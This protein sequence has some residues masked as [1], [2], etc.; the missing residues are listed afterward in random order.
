MS[1]SS[2]LHLPSS[3]SDAAINRSKKAS[4]KKEVILTLERK[5]LGWSHSTV[6]SDGEGFVN[7]LTDCLWYLDGHHSALKDRCM[8][9]P[10]EIDQ[11]QGFNN[12]EASK[13]KRKEVGNLDAS[14][15]D[16][17]S[18]SLNKLLLQPFF[19]LKRWK[20]MRGAVTSF[21]E[22]MTKYAMYLRKKCDSVKT[23]HAAL[24]PVRSASDHESVCLISEAV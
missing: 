15:L 7:L 9:I 17:Y 19:D 5:N 18:N 23:H 6:S 24:Q 4:M 21:V 10:S 14:T 12:P 2:K 20:G 3:P 16:A 1:G 11:F 13:H 22:C 8:E